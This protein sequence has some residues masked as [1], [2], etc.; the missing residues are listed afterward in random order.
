MRIARFLLL[1]TPF[2]TQAAD[3]KA[4]VTQQDG[5]EVVKLSDPSHHVEVSIA[6]SIGN[7]AY[8][9]LVD[10]HQILYIPAHSLAELKA[11][12]GLGGVPF[13]APWAN[14]IDGLSYWANNKKYLLNPDLGN[15]RLDGNGLPMH[16][17]LS[18][19]PLWKIV[20]TKAD[21]KSASVTS[22][23]EFWKYPDLLAQ[24]PF[25]H[26][27]EMTYTLHDGNLTVETV[28]KNLAE[29]P[30]PV[31]IGF[32]PYFQLDDAPRDAWQAH[33][34]VKEHLVLNNKVTPTGDKTPL[35]LSDPYPLAGHALDDGFSGIIRGADQRADFWVKG[36]TQQ[37]T[38]SYGPQ[39]TVAVVYAPPG[40]SFICFEPMSAL[41]NG[42]NLAHEGKW[43][44]LQ[45]VPAHG[46]WRENFEI[47]PT[48]F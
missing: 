33:L 43:D 29:D 44:G 35:D 41:T 12:P 25:P 15:L 40:R 17:L 46:E 27:V 9:M 5:M 2:M 39:F 13:L 1:L 23:L 7:M 37:I 26:V 18:F 21:N 34:P 28:L 48:G 6:P 10:G 31:A 16:G 36:K 4:L 14:R 3:Y 32:H 22:R 24:F 30:M 19:S 20:G 42:F 45:S 11:K 47:R 8:S 38:V